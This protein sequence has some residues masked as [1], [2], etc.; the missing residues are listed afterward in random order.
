MCHSNILCCVYVCGVGCMMVSS[1]ILVGV[2]VLEC[3]MGERVY[4]KSRGTSNWFGFVCM[5]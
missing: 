3:V 1:K 5:G 4:A 2:F